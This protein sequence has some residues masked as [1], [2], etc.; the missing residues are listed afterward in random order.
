MEIKYAI[1]W[2]TL[3][4]MVIILGIFP[5][6]VDIGAKL[7]GIATPT[8]ALFM[9]MIYVTYILSFM[10]FGYISQLNQKVKDL[11]YEVAILKK[12]LEDKKE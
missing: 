11:T 6:L 7:I 2:I 5:Q 3:S 8:S 12:E 9:G 10:A 1:I 4:V